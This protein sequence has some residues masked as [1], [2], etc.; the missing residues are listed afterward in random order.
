MIYLYYEVIFKIFF[1][2]SIP[3]SALTFYRFFSLYIFIRKYIFYINYTFLN[4]TLAYSFIYIN[5]IDI[6]NL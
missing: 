1:T 5:Y 2:K 4:F 3:A 6:Y